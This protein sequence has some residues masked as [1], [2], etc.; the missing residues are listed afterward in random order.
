[1]L[2]VY[3]HYTYFTLSVRGSTFDGRFWRQI[4]TPALKELM[5]ARISTWWDIAG[6]THSGVPR[7]N[8]IKVCAR[9]FF[10]IAALPPGVLCAHLRSGVHA[11][12]PGLSVYV[13]LRDV[14]EFWNNELVW[15]LVSHCSLTA[16]PPRPPGDTEKVSSMNAGVQS[17][18]MVTKRADGGPGAVVKATCLESRR[19]RV[20]TPLWQ[21]SFKESK[22][23]SAHS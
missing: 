18:E 11:R 8:P 22:C 20:R 7:S 6:G 15:I 2:W 12:G 16:P 3:G 21:S 1:M 10:A 14:L 19:S 23:L 9:S 4:L 13:S 5:T 17:Q